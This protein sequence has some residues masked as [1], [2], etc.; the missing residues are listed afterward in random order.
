MQEQALNP[1]AIKIQQICFTRNLDHTGDTT[2]FYLRAKETV[3]E[4][5]QGIATV[6]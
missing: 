5:S 2:M 1:G 4:F 3:L 6:L